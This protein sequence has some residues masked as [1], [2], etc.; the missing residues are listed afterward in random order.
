MARILFAYDGSPQAR[1]ALRYAA[2]LGEGDT[3]A[4]ISVLPALIEAP[5]TQE[6]TDPAVDAAEQ[7]RQLEEARGLLAATG[8]DVET[9]DVVGNPADEILTAAEARDVELI[10]L[11][12]HGQHAVQ[13]FLMGSVSDRVARHAVCDVLVVR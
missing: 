2:R 3:V 5:H 10:V 7:A 4:V 8:A 9:I 6:Y 1:R 13:R 12:R 11:G